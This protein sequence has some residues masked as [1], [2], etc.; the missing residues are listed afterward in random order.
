M[1]SAA[2]STGQ[3]L[4]LTDA[5]LRDLSPPSAHDGGEPSSARLRHALA[6]AQGNKNAAAKLLGLPSRFAL[7]RLMRKHG[8]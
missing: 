4:K 8:L 3:F 1:C 6:K 2:S 7:Y 5:V